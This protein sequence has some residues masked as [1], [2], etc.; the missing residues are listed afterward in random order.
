M[1][2]IGHFLRSTFIP[3]LSIVDNIQSYIFLKLNIKIKIMKEKLKTL[4]NCVNSYCI[5]IEH[6]ILYYTKYPIFDKWIF[7]RSN[8]YIHDFI[9]CLYDVCI[10]LKNI[11]YLNQ[12]GLLHFMYS[13]IQHII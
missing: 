10:Y 11:I 5:I 9:I 1:V 8:C 3:V 12:T 13:A 6:L 7:N 2:A 4:R